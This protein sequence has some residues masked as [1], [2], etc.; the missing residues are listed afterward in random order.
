VLV[1]GVLLATW[2]GAASAQAPGAAPPP[3]AQ[4]AAKV[5]PLYPGAAPGSET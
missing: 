5:I 4:G 2:A 3:P 1:A